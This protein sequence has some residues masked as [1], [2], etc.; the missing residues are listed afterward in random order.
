V[1]VAGHSAGGTIAADL[2]LAANRAMFSDP[3]VARNMGGSNDFD[4]EVEYTGL[5]TDDVVLTLG[6]GSVWTAGEA[7][8][9]GR[10]AQR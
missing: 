6:A 4:S 2:A 7:L 8:L 10:R 5:L 3:A 9:R 1:I